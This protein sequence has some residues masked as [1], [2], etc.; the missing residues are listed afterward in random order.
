[1]LVS[2]PQS[3]GGLEAP[4]EP[5]GKEA[6]GSASVSQPFDQQID[7]ALAKTGGKP[8]PYDPTPSSR[9]KAS[10][11]KQNGCPSAPD[12]Q[13]TSA[14]STSALQNPDDPISTADDNSLHETP[15]SRP[16]DRRDTSVITADNGAAQALAASSLLSAIQRPSVNMKDST[17]AEAQAATRTQSGLE[18]PP[19]GRTAVA[20]ANF[21]K[22]AVTSRPAANGSTLPGMSVPVQEAS[23]TRAKGDATPA[24]VDGVRSTERSENNPSASEATNT[25]PA[26][27]LGTTSAE[28][29]TSAQTQGADPAHGQLTA[30]FVDGV[31]AKSVSNSAQRP[32]AS[33]T[34]KD[35]PPGLGTSVAQQDLPMK[36]AEKVQ[37]TAEPSQQKLPSDSTV[38]AGQE[39]VRAALPVSTSSSADAEKL[40]LVSGSVNS[41]AGPEASISSA[42][43][44]T[45]S[46]DARLAT[47]EKTHDLVA[48]HALRLSQSGN[49]LLR[50]IIEPGGGTRL[51]LELRFGNGGIE[52]QA[53]LHG[54][55][56]QFLSSHW[57]ELQQRLEPRGV[58]LSALGC[59]DQPSSGQERFQQSSHQAAEEQPARS[60]FAEFALDGPMADSPAARRRG[61]KTHAG[62]ETWA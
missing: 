13:R 1:M 40:A 26:D 23:A 49:D 2:I 17:V 39:G 46:N 54:G 32:P 33:S 47:L 36:K 5:V 8:D 15:R 27:G 30:N 43:A 42:A 4:V 57:A 62:W 34:D 11:P 50:V 52:A 21:P 61:T 24:L 14:A 19:P 12:R 29:A 10:P 22:E 6:S 55:D 3:L 18:M 38:I 53:L 51:S 37:K 20:A 9:S 25:S 59:S 60:A 56:F 41:P 44:S 31:Q 58:H 35:Y 7:R 48:A 16:S 45:P 28:G